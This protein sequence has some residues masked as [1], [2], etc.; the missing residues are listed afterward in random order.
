MTARIP[1]DPRLAAI[2]DTMSRLCTETQLDSVLELLTALTRELISMPIMQD[3][4]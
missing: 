4:L 3:S 1:A 2:T